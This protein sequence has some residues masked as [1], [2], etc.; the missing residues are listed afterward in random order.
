MFTLHIYT[1]L[2]LENMIAIFQNPVVSCFC[3]VIFIWYNNAVHIYVISH[4]R[5]EKETYMW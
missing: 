1:R 3:F 5:K 4:K 2:L